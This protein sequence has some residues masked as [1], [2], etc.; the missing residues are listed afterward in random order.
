MQVTDAMVAKALEAYDAAVPED[1]GASANGMEAALTAALAE[2]W[3]RVP[4]WD[5]YEV[6]ADGDV[7][8]IDRTIIGKDG[9]PKIYRGKYL[10]SKKNEFGYLTVHLREPGRDCPAMRVHRLVAMAF[11]PNP[12]GK[13]N[14]NHIDCDPTNNCVS[15]LEWCTQEENMQHMHKLGRGR[16]RKGQRPTTAKLTSEQVLALRHKFAT[17]QCTRKSLSDEYGVC[18]SA[19]DRIVTRRTYGHIPDSLPAPP[20]GK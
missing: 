15:N 13:P 5:G 18:K 19:I 1:H 2:M 11:I 9:V 8:S 3:R 6:N 16:S 10:T 20:M 14:I 12:D 4:G 17:G 7:R